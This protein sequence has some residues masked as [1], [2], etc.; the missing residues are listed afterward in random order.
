MSA[1]AQDSQ[2][3]TAFLLTRLSTEVTALILV[4]QGATARSRSGLVQ[5]IRVIAVIGLL[6]QLLLQIT[7]RLHTRVLYL[8]QVLTL[9]HSCPLQAV[10][11]QEV[12][13]ATHHPAAR[14]IPATRRLHRTLLRTGLIIE[15]L[16]IAHIDSWSLLQINSFQLER[17]SIANKSK[18]PEEE[19][20]TC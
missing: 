5:A 12:Q 1:I 2:I 11:Y 13:A 10:V 4:R 3:K 18:W 20:A 14:I 15:L 7:P 6:R 8:R 16:N 19:R 9:L 17:V